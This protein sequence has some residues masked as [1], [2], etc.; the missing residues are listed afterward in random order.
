MALVWEGGMKGP[1]FE[2]GHSAQIHP[3]S[4]TASQRG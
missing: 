4:A 2:E 1:F 3:D